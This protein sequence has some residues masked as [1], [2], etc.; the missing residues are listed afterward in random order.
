MIP[1]FLIPIFIILTTSNLHIFQA[2]S[3]FITQLI[4]FIFH[5]LLSNTMA[6]SVDMIT[7]TSKDKKQTIT[8][9]NY[10]ELNLQ[11]PFVDNSPV[12]KKTIETDH[13]RAH[14]RRHLGN[15]TRNSHQNLH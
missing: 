7:F 4:L 6:S 1:L 9:P 10:T 12:I 8:S 11:D 3:H 13:T 14:M 2:N 5:Y 15:N